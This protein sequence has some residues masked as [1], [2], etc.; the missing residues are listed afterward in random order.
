LSITNSDAGVFK[1]HPYKKLQSLSS[2]TTKITFV[3]IVV[4]C[5]IFLYCTGYMVTDIFWVFSS[6]I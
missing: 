4:V 5:L 6:F 3:N 1:S 2:F